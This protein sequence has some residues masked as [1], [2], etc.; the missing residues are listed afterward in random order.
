MSKEKTLEVLRRAAD[1][2]GFLAQ[3]ADDAARTLES[4]DLTSEEKAA[5]SSG[6]VR[7]IENHV[8]KLDKALMTWLKC[9]LEQEKW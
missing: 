1:D 7:W 4:Y 8:G 5:L 2:N 6:D 3:L 9:R